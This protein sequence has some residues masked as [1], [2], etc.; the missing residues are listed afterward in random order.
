MA[1]F[2]FQN[3]LCLAV[4]QLKTRKQ[5]T[6]ANSNS[7]WAY[8]RGGL[9]SEGYLG[10]GGGA[11]FREGLFFI[12]FFFIDWLIDRSIDRSIDW[13]IDWLFFLFVGGGGG[14][15]IIGILRYVDQ[16]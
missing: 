12:F 3:G 4:K 13:L 2:S 6:K 8:I 7:P 14:G 15:V 16:M 5:P 9:L 11:Y 1:Y 10:G